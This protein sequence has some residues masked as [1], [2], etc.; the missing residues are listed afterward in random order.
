[1]NVFRDAEA[2]ERLNKALRRPST[3]VNIGAE[4]TQYQALPNQRSGMPLL[5]GR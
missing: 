1:M 5:A 3:P 4:E 2:N